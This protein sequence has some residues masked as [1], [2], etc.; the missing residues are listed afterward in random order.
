ML[1]ESVRQQS[2]LHV[3]PKFWDLRMVRVS[4]RRSGAKNLGVAAGFLDNLCIPD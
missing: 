2:G 3:T 1:Q 4:F